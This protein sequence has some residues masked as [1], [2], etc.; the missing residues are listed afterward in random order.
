MYCALP[1]FAVLRERLLLLHAFT[2]E[3]QIRRALGFCG[4]SQG[5]CKIFRD[6]GV[7]HVPDLHLSM[8]R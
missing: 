5:V 6:E 7:S 4:G 3:R 1:K 8:Y 2:S